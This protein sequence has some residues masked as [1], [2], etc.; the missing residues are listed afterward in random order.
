MADRCLSHKVSDRHWRTQRSLHKLLK[1]EKA[2]RLSDKAEKN[3][4]APSWCRSRFRSM[5]EASS[6]GVESSAVSACA[7]KK[8][9]TRPSED[10]PALDVPLLSPWPSMLPPAKHTR[11]EQALKAAGQAQAGPRRQ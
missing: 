4:G 6:F 10:I 3:A 7:L 2:Q 11:A 1:I 5:F 9:H 8:K